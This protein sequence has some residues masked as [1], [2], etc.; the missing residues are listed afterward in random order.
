M[1]GGIGINGIL[2]PRELAKIFALSYL[3]LDLIL[4]SPPDSDWR[5]D[6]DSYDTKAFKFDRKDAR[7]EPPP[8]FPSM[9]CSA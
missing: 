7:V 5:W 8:E 2:L 9:V 1:A 4:V 6:T 3:K